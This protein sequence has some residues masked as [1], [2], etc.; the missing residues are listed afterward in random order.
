MKTISTYYI[1]CD[2]APAVSTLKT[3]FQS[4][5]AIRQAL[6]WTPQ[7]QRH[8]KRPRNTWKRSVEAEMKAAGLSW[9]DVDE[10]VHRG[11]MAERERPGS[12]CSRPGSINSAKSCTVQP[13]CFVSKWRA[14]SLR[15]DPPGTLL[16]AIVVGRFRRVARCYKFKSRPCPTPISCVVGAKRLLSDLLASRGVASWTSLVTSASPRWPQRL[17]RGATYA[18]SATT[19]WAS[20][21]LLTVVI[22]GHQLRRHVPASEHQ[23][24]P[25]PE[26]EGSSSHAAT[27]SNAMLS[28]YYTWTQDACLV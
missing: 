23:R 3:A 24:R 22:C 18:T 7:G 12:S 5:I 4:C 13:M 19:N 14:T 2:A 9:S 17:T 15:V 8:K 11:V 1:P 27:W 26:Q 10:V 6:K 21:S 25:R 28:N 20:L 16:A